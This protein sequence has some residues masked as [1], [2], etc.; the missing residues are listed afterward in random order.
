MSASGDTSGLVAKLSM[1]MK[2]VERIPKRGSNAFHGYK[3][4]ME[5][6][7]ADVVRQELVRQGVMLIPSLKAYELHPLLKKGEPAGVICYATY[8]FTATDGT[9][10]ISFDVLGAGS[11]NPGD[12]A[13]YKAFTGAEKYALMKLLLIP[14]GDDPERD[15][16]EKPAKAKAAEP[17][18][19]SL[20]DRKAAALAIV[21][22][23]VKV[24]GG[25][26]EEL[27]Q[28]ISD[29]V[30]REVKEL[31]LRDLGELEKL[32]KYAADVKDAMTRQGKLK[33]V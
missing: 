27:A 24:E 20:A 11:D 28:L 23:A 29:V 3:Y 18:G 19:P 4:A 1:V 10:S 30:G 31:R 14:T 2:E 13:P 6:D 33:G 12:K 16:E 25:K 8:T 17:S 32:E 21:E 7:V 15:E 9:G 5:A 22:A 26:A